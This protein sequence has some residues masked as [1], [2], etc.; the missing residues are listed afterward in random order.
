MNNV[1]NGN[2]TC[3]SNIQKD[4]RGDID[5]TKRCKAMGCFLLRLKEFGHSP[6]DVFPST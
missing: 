5:L 6:V 1:S 3:D 4:E 2:H